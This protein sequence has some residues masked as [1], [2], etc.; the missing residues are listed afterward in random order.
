MT[1][2]APAVTYSDVIKIFHALDLDWS[3]VEETIETCED[4]DERI[5]VLLRWID[6]QSYDSEWKGDVAASLL[7]EHLDE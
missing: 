2:T 4:D 5:G 3:D 6:S 1:N 7:E